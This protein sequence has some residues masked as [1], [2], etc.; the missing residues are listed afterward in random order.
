M[1]LVEHSVVPE[2]FSLRPHPPPP[3]HR[4]NKNSQTYSVHERLI[5]SNE[6]ITI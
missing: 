1:T 6:L 5:L 2:H 4:V 3:K